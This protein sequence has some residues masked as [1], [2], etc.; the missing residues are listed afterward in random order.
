MLHALFP[1][2]WTELLTFVLAGLALN[3]APGSDVFF[4]TASGLQGGPRA[5]LA[6]GLG[7]G[8]GS[9]V[10]VALAALG[11]GVLVQTYPTAPVAMKYAGAAYLL[12]MAW[13]SWTAAAPAPGPTGIRPALSPFRA[14]RGAFLINLFNPKTLLFI[15]AFL[16]QFAHPALGPVGPQILGL[17]LIFTL[18]GTLVTA[19][20]GL[21]AGLAGAALSPHLHILNRLAAL[22][23]TALAAKLLME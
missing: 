8:A 21:A 19:L 3:I 20:Y 6:A 18:T 15:F 4:A 22:V 1:L 2:P 11:L 12:V 23:F 13:K 16:T 7:T 5:G 17:G 14:F 10:N 9:L